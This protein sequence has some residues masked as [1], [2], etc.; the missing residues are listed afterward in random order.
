MLAEH[1]EGE[2][3]A[4][5]LERAVP[6]TPLTGLPDP[7]QD[8]VLTTLLRRLWIEPPAGHRFRPLSALCDAWA[9]EAEPDLAHLDPGLVRAD[10]ALFRGL[11]RDDVPAVLLPTDMHAGN[12][13]AA[14]R[15]RGAAQR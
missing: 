13:L 10:L 6:G 14:R 8:V 5:L 1:V 3:A 7:E 15:A 2:T 12:V 4:L 9:A 11:P